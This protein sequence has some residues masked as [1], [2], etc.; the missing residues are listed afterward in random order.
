M[1]DILDVDLLAFERGSAKDRIA[2]VDGVMRSLSTGFVYTKHDLSEDML[3]ETYDVLSEFFALPSK[4]K[5]QYVASGARGQTGYT[6]LLVETAAIS[7]T[8]DW[9][10]MLNWGTPLPPGHPLRDRYP[11]RYGDPIFPSQHISNAAEILTHFH[12][13]LVEL[14]TRFLRIIATGVGANENYFD[15][16]LRHG[17]HLTRAIRYPP[18]GEAP[19]GGNEGHVWAEE[20]GDINLITA[21]PRATAR[22]LQ[23]KVDNK[24]VDAEPPDGHVIINTGIMLERLTNGLVPVGWHRVV[25]DTDQSEGRLSV[26]QFCHPTPWTIL[27]PIPSTVSPERPCNFPAMSAGDCLDQVL[28][29]INLSDE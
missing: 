8:P 19:S 22:G 3:D 28:W 5:E 9:K 13:C 6:G 7:N 29:E 16:M 14:Q 4:S 23:V 18:M 15:T 10:E 27:S 2:T 11:H 25:A 26:V 21:L 12:E 20:H 17:S 1:T 24:W